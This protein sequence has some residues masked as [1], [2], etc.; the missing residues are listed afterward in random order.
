MTWDPKNQEITVS[1]SQFYC[2]W[3]SARWTAA[4]VLY[5]FQ[6]DGRPEFAIL[7][8]LAPYGLFFRQPSRQLE[9]AFKQE[10]SRAEIKEHDLDNEKLVKIM[11]SLEHNY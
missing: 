3:C 1:K 5:S 8:K 6:N 11:S 7:E 9:D 4:E 2:S 10:L